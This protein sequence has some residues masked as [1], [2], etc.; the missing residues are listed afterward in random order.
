[1]ASPLLLRARLPAII[2]CI[3]ALAF[4]AVA[5][6]LLAGEPAADASAS[7]A[8]VPADAPAAA[9]ATGNSAL[10]DP[11]LPTYKTATGMSGS[12]KSIGSDTMNNLMTLWSEG[13]KRYYPQRPGGD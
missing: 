13:F 4:V 6:G 5:A 9:P 8:S 11:A 12:I 10:V 3:A 2:V 7:D 1:M